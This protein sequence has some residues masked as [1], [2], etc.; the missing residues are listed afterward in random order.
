GTYSFEEDPIAGYTLGTPSPDSVTID[1]ANAGSTV[2]VTCT[3]TKITGI[4]KLT[5]IGLDEGVVA[6]FT[7]YNSSDEPLGEKTITGVAPGNPDPFVTWDDVPYGSG[8]YIKETDTPDGYIKMDDITD[9]DIAEQDQ[10]IEKSAEN[11]KYSSIGDY[12]WN[13][14][15]N[16]GIQDAGEPPLA[17]ITVTLVG[18]S[19]TIGTQ[20]MSTDANGLYLFKNLLQGTYTVTVDTADPD[21]PAG[22]ILTTTGSYLVNLAAG[23][24]YLTA[25]F[26]FYLPSVPTTTITT[27]TI[28]VAGLVEEPVEEPAERVIEVLG[29]QVLPFTGLNLDLLT[30]A[31]IATVL[32]GLVIIIVLVSKRSRKQ[33]E[34]K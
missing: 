23:E 15:N 11:I 8:Y 25:D 17:N 21:L 1:A 14:M 9:I 6:K 19:G 3:N 2:E 10:I 28:T 20:T 34:Q 33:K 26:G 7:L 5:K 16:N 18:T 12:V 32:G 30:Y 4:V 22:F 27:T 24:N 29:I 13:D 31:G